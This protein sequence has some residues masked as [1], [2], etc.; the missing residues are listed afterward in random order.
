MKKI[1][2]VLL[3]VGLNLMWLNEAISQSQKGIVPANGIEIAYE[4]FGPIDGEAV[5]LI[6]GTGSQLTRWPKEFVEE[7]AGYGYRVIQFDNRDV[8]LSTKL[9]SLGTPDWASIIPKIGTCD[10]SV[11][12]YGLQDMADD[13]IGLMDAMDI[14]KAHIV[15][16]SMGGVIAQLLAFSYPE[17]TLS[18]V[19]MMTSSGNPELPPE[20]PEVLKIMSTPPPDTNN[21]KVLTEYVFRINKALSSP[22][23]PTSDA[24]LREMAKRDIKRSWYPVGT[25]RQVAAIAM[26]CDRREK[27]KKLDMPVIVIHGENDPVVNIEAGRELARIIPDAKLVTFPGMA[28]DLPTSLMPKISNVLK[29]IS[30]GK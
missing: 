10:T 17:R 12:P 22:G 18:L 27:L 15:G 21:I 26:E 20:D 6:Q 16:V 5:I 14:E 1:I 13:V 8:G 30:N 29:K 2:N 19:L 24:E 4:S 23:Y 3:I 28:H 9:D 11:L 25:A 7:L